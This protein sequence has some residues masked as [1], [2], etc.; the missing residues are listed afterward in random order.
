MTLLYGV[1][2]HGLECHLRYEVACFSS[3]LHANGIQ[4]GESRG[5]IF[6]EP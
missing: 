5:N 1:I 4:I 6:I 3:Q 2:R